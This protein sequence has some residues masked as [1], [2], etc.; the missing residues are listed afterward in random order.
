MFSTQR[1][2]TL[3]EFAVAAVLFLMCLFG[4]I[5]FG[6]GVWQYNM[7]S[8]LAQ[9][10]ARLAA[11]CGPTKTLTNAACDVSSYVQGRAL[12][13]DVTVTFPLGNPSAIAPGSLVAVKVTHDFGPHLALLPT[14][15]IRLQST[16]HMVVAR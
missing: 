2:E 11:V 16:S 15:T 6:L 14:G 10:G 12:G 3:V 4:T 8:N 7:V 13:M 9:E 5:E 1:G